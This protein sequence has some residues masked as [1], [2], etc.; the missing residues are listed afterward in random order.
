MEACLSH[1]DEH[2][3]GAVTADVTNMHPGGVPF[4]SEVAVS[5]PYPANVGPLGGD[6]LV[7]H[8]TIG[9]T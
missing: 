2:V 3:K 8:I 5:V 7:I 1:V 4:C 6:S 9:T